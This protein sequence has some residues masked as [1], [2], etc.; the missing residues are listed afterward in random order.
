MK[1]WTTQHTGIKD[2]SVLKR[3]A[4]LRLLFTYLFTYLHL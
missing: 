4:P 3:L 2:K 1:Q